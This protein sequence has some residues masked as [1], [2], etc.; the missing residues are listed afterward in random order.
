LTNPTNITDLLPEFSAIY[1]DPSI[2]D[3]ATHAWIQVG[4]G[5]NQSDKWSSGWIDIPNVT[6]GSRSTNISYVAANL[7]INTTYYWR[8]R[9]KDEGG[10]EGEWS[11]GN[12]TFSIKLAMDPWYGGKQGAL[13]VETHDLAPVNESD[14]PYDGASG[15]KYVDLGGHHESDNKVRKGI[16]KLMTEFPGLILTVGMI[17]KAGNETDKQVDNTTGKPQNLTDWINSKSY[18]DRLI[19]TPHGY[20][21]TNDPLDPFRNT[22]MTE[23]WYKARVDEV[24]D[25]FVN[26]TNAGLSTTR[27]YVPQ[28]WSWPNPGR[29]NLWRALYSAGWYTPE[30][31]GHY[32][33]GSNNYNYT[34]AELNDADYSITAQG[35]DSY[36][37]KPT[38]WEDGGI[39]KILFIISNSNPDGERWDYD[40]AKKIIEHGHLCILMGHTHNETGVNDSI[41]DDFSNYNETLQYIYN[42]TDP[43]NTTI[44]NASF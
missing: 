8:I 22:S 41:W 42:S 30:I 44:E 4:T 25:M 17:P 7:T 38:I 6:K 15:S 11:A 39:E 1:N 9:F 33:D 23:A 28:G 24:D 16:D 2:S 3:I 18:K 10:L 12:D 21:H 32:R 19:L 20:Y 26:L 27:Q 31:W 5:E 36:I 37:W 13:S 34:D 35:L 29:E 14:G 43:W 40:T